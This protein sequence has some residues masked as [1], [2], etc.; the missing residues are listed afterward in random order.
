MAA[1]TLGCLGA[2]PAEP[3]AVV[4]EVS[5]FRIALVN[6]PVVE[7]SLAIEPDSLGGILVEGR[8]RTIGIGGILYPIDNLYRALLD[9]MS[10]L[11][12][13][14]EKRIDQADVQQSLHAK[15]NREIGWVDYGEHGKRPLIEGASWFIAVG[16]TL[17]LESWEI[18]TCR[19]YPLEMEGRRLTMTLR[20]LEEVERKVLGRT[21][22]CIVVEAEFSEPKPRAD[23]LLPRTDMLTYHLIDDDFSWRFVVTRESPSM[24]A[25]I[26]LK[27]SPISIRAELTR[28]ERGGDA[29]V[30][31]RGGRSSHRRRGS[32]ADPPR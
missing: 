15:A 2:A 8:A 16:A 6:V 27:R 25:A 18:G 13:W 29:W 32:K 21:R 30:K 17:H 26:E 31:P 4:P 1:T 14:W 28:L 24:L 7:A 19:G 20:G 3:M 22:R 23:D 12:R 10:G 9:P 5:T 11:P